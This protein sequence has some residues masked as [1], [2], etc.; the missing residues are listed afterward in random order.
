[1]CTPTSQPIPIGNGHVADLDGAYLYDPAKAKELLTEA[2]V[3]DLELD[4][5][6]AASGAGLSKVLAA[7]IAYQL[8]LSIQI[9]NLFRAGNATVPIEQMVAAVAP[10]IQVDAYLGLD[11]PGTVPPELRTLGDAVAAAPFDSPE[12]TTALE[13]HSPRGRE[14]DQ[15]PD[16][17]RTYPLRGKPASLDWRTCRGA[18]SRVTRT[19]A[20]LAW[21][22]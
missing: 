17:R 8:E 7:P 15:H 22:N 4:A 12:S 10:S 20:D 14:P 6:F 5:N 21:Q 19:F 9:R 3:P 11:N 13:F 1:M 18:R 2:G 16:M